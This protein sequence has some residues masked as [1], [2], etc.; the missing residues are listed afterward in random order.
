MDNKDDLLA[1]E[2][3]KILGV[4]SYKN[5]DRIRINR[6]LKYRDEDFYWVVKWTDKQRKVIV[7]IIK[8]NNPDFI[9]K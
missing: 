8:R 3:N 5:K 6:M 2:L 4:I 9:F 7:S 1:L